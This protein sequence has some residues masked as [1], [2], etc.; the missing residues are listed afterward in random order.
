[1]TFWDNYRK[2]QFQENENNA[3]VFSDCKMWADPREIG[4]KEGNLHD[5][6]S[7]KT[8]SRL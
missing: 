2:I 6:S 7:I 5:I 8:D 1:M 4:N 3:N